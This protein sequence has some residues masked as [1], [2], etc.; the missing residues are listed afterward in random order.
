LGRVTPAEPAALPTAS[1]SLSLRDRFLAF[2]NR[3][4]ASARFQRWAAGFPLTRPVALRQSRALFDLCAGFVYSQV[5]AAC[6]KL[7]LFETLEPGPLSVA[8]LCARLDMPDEGM[9]CL[10]RAAVSLN[11]LST[12]S[13][14]RYGLGM[15][16][17]ALLGNPGVSRMIEHH[18]LLYADLSDP[19][20]L[21][22]GSRNTTALSNF[23]P[24]TIADDP[25]AG[26]PDV[27][28]TYSNLMSASQPLVA[29]EILGSFDFSR[30]KRHLDIG[31]GDGTFIRAVAKQ[32]PDLRFGLFDLPPVCQV[33]ERRFTAAAMLERVTLHPG[34]L[35]TDVIPGGYDLITLSRILHD[36]EDASVL[37]L[38]R[39]V[40]AA[41]SPGGTLL[42]AEPMSGA[43]GAEA[44]G[45]GYFGLYLF[46]M[47]TGRPR[48]PDEITDLLRKS[49]FSRVQVLRTRRPL[50]ARVIT[51]C[52]DMS[53]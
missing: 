41:L 31:G 20:A 22:R 51:A 3:V 16:G 42:I 29:E 8:Q 53:N 52:A 40:K 38:L 14:D 26:A 5:L 1:S 45:D 27:A 33:A 37:S 21:L 24:Y 13:G 35:H 7:K 25:Q 19:V 17:A 9:R 44:M 49:G 36:H 30:H 46:A 50:L 11:L 23:W 48:R 12:H 34:N 4:V 47:G 6:V 2:R 28:E 32:A 10:L 18:A 39:R 15:L 43:P